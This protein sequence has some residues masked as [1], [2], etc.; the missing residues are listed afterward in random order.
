MKFE[1]WEMKKHINKKIFMGNTVYHLGSILSLAHQ[2]YQLQEVSL[3][4]A[5]FHTIE[6]DKRT[7][8][9]GQKLCHCEKNSFFFFFLSFFS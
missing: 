7:L 1:Y 3:S 5:Q 8:P 6:I 2:K 4:P 9:K